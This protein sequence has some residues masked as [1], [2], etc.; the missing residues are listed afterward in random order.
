[1]LG[2]GVLMKIDFIEVKNFR[3]LFST[4][5]D[6]DQQQTLLVGANNSGKT[7]AMVALRKF[8]GSKN[9]IEIND[10]SL[11]N[12]QKINSIGEAW[13]KG[14]EP[15]EDLSA[16]LP[17]MDLW[18][19]VPTD[20]IRHIIHVV[21]T[22]N[23][24][25]G[26]LGVRFNF[27][28]RDLKQMKADFLEAR[29]DAVK[30]LSM[31][32]DLAKNPE[33]ENPEEEN[34]K[35]RPEN[36]IEFL[37]DN[38]MTHIGLDVF[39]LNPD[40]IVKP[41]DHGVATLQDLP[42][43]AVK[44]SNQPFE[45]LIKISEISAQR[46]LHDAGTDTTERTE[47]NISRQHLSKQI[48][49]YYDDH[50]KGEKELS[51]SDLNA[52]TALF[53][54]EKAFDKKIKSSLKD[55]L[56][57]LED[58]GIP[59]INNPSVVVNTKLTAIEGLNHGSA[60]Q[61]Q[62]FEVEEG[63]EQ[64]FLPE[65]YAGLGY[66]NLISMMFKLMRFRQDWIEGIKAHK[67]EYERPLLHLVLLEE[68]EAF[69]HAQVQQVFINKAYGVLRNHPDLKDKKEFTTQ[70][71]VSS[72]SSHIAHEVD[73]AHLRY[74]RRHNDPLIT[75]VPITTVVNLA[76]TFDHALGAPLPAE[77]DDTDDDKTY[78][79]VKRYL[80]ATHCDIFFADAVIFVEGQAERILLPH[81]IRYHY[82]ELW[83][84]Y[85][86]IIECGGAHA[87][88]F[89]PLIRHLGITTLVVGDLDAAS[90]TIVDTKSGGTKTVYK[91]AKPEIG[92]GQVTTNPV[93]KKWHPKISQIDD[94]LSVT[95]EKLGIEVNNNYKLGV[96]YQRPVEFNMD[97]DDVTVIPRT[98]EDAFIYQNQEQ[99]KAISE[100]TTT[101]KINKI[102][103]S[104]YGQEELEQE[105]F[106]LVRKMN[107]AEFAIEC[108]YEFKDN[109]LLR[110]PLY[111]SEG[112]NW[113]NR[114]LAPEVSSG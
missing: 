90:E 44:L 95:A 21:P 40:K 91:A 88:K 70:L 23:W 20:E 62:V 11:A 83:K 2:V 7:S 52:L 60:V 14:E 26:S 114:T 104:G 36:L 6:F 63:S 79:F 4:R 13:E 66:Q 81:F 72:H 54:A 15:S 43:I 35:F 25:G 64:Y 112:L 101:N 39:P 8:L 5:I 29:K 53:L 61:Y 82:P 65:T 71:L 94:L 12:W 17:I 87:H 93:L 98:F 80:K 68:P 106:E 18:L 32:T 27:N 99:L 57:E 50:L 49:R 47:S 59:G 48:R 92:K 69:L 89:E 75:N 67:G 86:S 100:S 74:F 42:E 30:N 85:I 10:V 34:P 33:E 45:G 28:A 58:M 16:L 110:P 105:L 102:V 108:L 111:I 107:K 56:S 103:E 19:D 76:N 73:F 55:P 97:G 51:E 84:R 1:M 31:L 46:D 22:L 78:R 113:L 24:K 9:S 96:C 38:K 41:N 37:T 3:K 109:S 77:E